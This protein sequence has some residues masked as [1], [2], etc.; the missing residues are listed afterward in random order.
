MRI[1]F[2]TLIPFFF[3]LNDIDAQRPDIWANEAE[4][5]AI[6][7]KI[8]TQDWANTY[9]EDFKSSADK[10][11]E[12]LKSN[13]F[14]KVKKLPFLALT[15]PNISAFKYFN[16]NFP[17]K[18]DD[19]YRLLFIDLL[20]TGVDCGVMYY[21]TKD[22]KYADAGSTILFNV[23]EALAKTDYAPSIHNSGLVTLEDHL[24]EAR[25][26]GS[27]LPIIYDFLHPFLKKP[28]S[29]TNI[30]SG[31]KQDFNFANAENVFKKYIHLVL[32]KGIIDCNWPFLEGYS[33]V[34]NI[35]AL[36]SKVERDSLIQYFLTTNTPN[37]DALV[38]A[39]VTYQENGGHWPESINYAMGVT[40]HLIYLMNLVKRQYPE[41]LFTKDYPEVFQASM[42]AYYL[43][44]PNNNEMVFYGDGFRKYNPPTHLLELTYALAKK[45]DN[46]DLASKSG[47]ILKQL[48]L[49][50]KYNRPKNS[51]AEPL[52]YDSPTNLLWTQETIES[53]LENAIQQLPVTNGLKFA[54]LTV[55][56]NLADAPKHSLMASTAGGSFVHGHASG[57]NIELYGQ[58]HVL[59]VKN[60]KSRYRTDIHENYYRLF[61]A[62]NTIVVNGKSQGNGGW[63][64][65]QTQTV[66][67]LAIEPKYFEKPVSP[68]HSFVLSKFGEVQDDTV[69]VSQ[70][71]LLGIVRTSPTSGFY[72]D[73]YR[74]KTNQSKQFHDYIYHN[75]G[76]EVKVT[77]EKGQTPSFSKDEERFIPR[78][79]QKWI[80]N[81][82]F[83][84]PGWHFFE[85]VK[86]AI[87]DQSTQALFTASKLGKEP[88]KMKMFIPNNS[89]I[90]IT[91]CMSPPAVQESNF[92][93]DKPTPTL[94]IRKNEEVWEKPFVAIFESSTTN[95]PSLIEKVSTIEEKGD[96]KCVK[97]DL[98][99]DGIPYSHYILFNDN[100]DKKTVLKKQK[101]QFT[102]RYAVISFNN[103][104]KK[105][106]EIYVGYSQEIKV[107]TLSFQSDMNASFYVDCDEKG[108]V[109]KKEVKFEKK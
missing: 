50:G 35:F 78:P 51:E 93:N 57:M 61:A 79:D 55:Q 102:G 34:S 12:A 49:E 109:V 54:G 90:D 74:S 36:E 53:D 52:N 16:I 107:G 98:K 101:I 94:V 15:D 108:K 22:E 13:G 83:I 8:K 106:S 69:F 62:H 95:N 60:G 82:S 17:S 99:K 26:I 9:F 38:K 70:Q 75:I 2:L 64:N 58:G 80:Q 45:E 7:H 5:P 32:T 48:M 31:N 25:L 86:T 72:V 27:K 30:I 66:E 97:V 18:E 1:Y 65:L 103:K 29:C 42:E 84:N 41:I 85:N 4:L 21:L 28:K 40:S 104:T 10:R 96:V 59:G 23:I 73:V 68:N 24:Y 6:L 87:V 56:R 11:I 89:K 88:V 19:G 92:Y 14:Q 77:D 91:T 105:L 63:V 76:D 43:S 47:G 39:K 81:R 71:R 67:N 37:Q 20:N 46:K 44:Y 3:V 33:L 100:S